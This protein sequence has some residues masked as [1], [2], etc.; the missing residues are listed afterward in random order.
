MFYRL[1]NQILKSLLIIFSFIL[2]HSC[3]PIH[4][5][6]TAPSKPS[7]GK[8]TKIRFV[9][10]SLNTPPVDFY[11][12]GNKL[13]S[14][15]SYKMA[16][17][18]YDINPGIHEFR[19]VRNSDSELLL[20]DTLKL[21]SNKIYVLQFNG[22]PNDYSLKLIERTDFSVQ[23]DFSFAR[24]INSSKELG[25][26]DIKVYNQI[27]NYLFSELGYNSN[28]G[29][30]K[31]T[32]GPAKIDIFRTQ[33]EN[34]IFSSKAN[35]EG[36]KVYSVFLSGNLSTSDSTAL[37]AYFLDETKNEEQTL[38]NFEVG[39]TK[40]RFVNGISTA[41]SIQIL[42]DDV[43]LRNSLGFNQ[44]TSFLTFKAGARKLKIN[45]GVSAG[46]L[47]TVIV[48]DELKTYTVYFS[49]SLNNFV[50][51][52][53]SNE[54][55]SVA[56][57][58]SLIR[59]LNSTVDLQNVLINLTSISGRT[60]VD[61]PNYFL[62]SNYVEVP[63]GQNLITL[64]SSGKPNLLS[65]EAFLE[66]GRVYTAF[67]SGSYL[68]TSQNPLRLS[69]IKDN[70][71]IA[72]NLFTFEQVKSNLRLVNASPDLVS[73]D[74]E[75]DGVKLNTEEINYKFASRNYQINTGFRTVKTKITNDINPFFQHTL[76][77]E[78]N[79]NY[80]L[81]A[82]D[83]LQTP[84]I[85]LLESGQRTVP[86]GKSSV[87]F[88]NGI[89]DLNSVDIKI[90]N[91]SGTINLTQNIFKNITTYIDLPAG[92][93]QFIITT[94]TGQQLLF[95][96]EAQLEVGVAYTAILS[97]ISDGSSDK[98]YSIS[99]L[100]ES[101]DTYHKLTE[102]A[103]IKTNLRFVN[104]ITDNPVVDLYADEKQIATNVP[105]KLATSLIKVSSGKNINLKVTR[106]GT[107]TQL[108]SKVVNIDY[109][110]EYSYI[111]CGEINFPDG[112]LIENPI[113]TAPSGKSSVR[114]IHGAS[115][116]GSMAVNITNSTGTVSIPSVQFK[117]ASNY[118]D[119][120]S[121]RN[122]ITVTIST[123][124]GNIILTSDANL[125]ENKVYS[126]YVIGNSSGSGE[127]ALDIYFLDETNSGAQTLFKFSAIKSKLRFINGSTDNPVLELNV[128]NEFV[129][130]NVTYKLATSI[131][132][133]NSGVNKSVKVFEFGSTIPLLSVNLTLS[134]A[135]NYSLLV[136]NQKTNLE[137]I[138]FENPSKTV[139]PGKVAVRVVHGAYDL[140]TVD[141]T[142]NNYT[143]KTKISN[144][145]YKGVS[146]YIDL[147]A[148]FNEIIITRTS[149]PGS[150][151][152]AIDATLEEGKLYTIYLLGNSSGN[153][154]EEY[155]LNFLDENN[156]GGQFLFT[157][158]PS[159][160]ARM[161]FINASPNSPGLDVS[162]D[163]SKFAQNVLFGNSSGYLFMRSGSRE[164]KVTPGGQNNPVLI[165]F[166]YLFE[167]NRLYSLLVMDSVSNIT[168]VLIEDMNFTLD[169]GKA[170]VRFI[171]ASSNS[172]PFDIKIGNPSGVIKHS[173]FT[174]QQISSYE[175]YD[176]Q[177]LSFVFTRTNST[178]ELV[179]LRG[180]SLIAGKVY[181]IV[182][183]GFYQG[184]TGQHLQIKWFQ[185]N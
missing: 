168:P 146:S 123:I 56:G 164:L 109:A 71:S 98:K 148:G 161:R 174:Y 41:Q 127:Q 181:T 171:N 114:F 105:Y 156:P 121:G 94:T 52:K 55:Q 108:F 35:F 177:I 125:E 68:S 88:V 27:D 25:A 19:I 185:D 63:T 96:S 183:M 6:P 142:F 115:G 130:T 54:S 13:Y 154:G 21:D 136:T 155:S 147:P 20:K 53:L 152:L 9:N 11:V 145:N 18:L 172:P 163:D 33:T 91:S 126:V 45:V 104:A 44:S 38:F 7:L 166:N 118:Y 64:S 184:Q 81:L 170:Y 110:K 160:I 107:I 133:V 78:V 39:T 176:P 29:F 17:A 149:S 49:N 157:Y 85:L 74:L 135:K 117:N 140:S 2:F 62:S 175:P 106:T 80:I 82:V 138:F 90:I 165:N 70:D 159:T 15:S 34:L 58:R 50:A 66:G 72:Q 65:I 101:N 129:A 178:E 113:K 97:G 143:S 16:T 84:D 12:D 153:F 103:P 8:G 14:Y 131:L 180:F 182:V 99:F 10:T 37:N 61:I 77:V 119:L 83:K 158:T 112:F 150:L 42:V 73:V 162:L 89:Y 100:K 28:S 173:Y 75:V 169:E 1:L 120:I 151:I 60:I 134:H 79:K 4:D 144:L 137:Y 47:D 139:A 40:I 30:V 24:F 5:W 167:T 87:R 32:P 141:I 51:V 48:F 59:F 23:V 57:N 22:T 31:L 93:N 46:Y 76:N 69:F 122:Q 95:T 111:A 116:L 128:D 132:N 43:L 3:G 92:K 26:I 86:F 179:S 102:F 67:I 124:S 36:G